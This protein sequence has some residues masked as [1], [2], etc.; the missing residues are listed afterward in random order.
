VT[1]LGKRS[2]VNWIRCHV[3]LID[4]A[5]DLASMVLPT[6]GTSSRSTWPSARRATIARRTVPPLPWIARSTFSAMRSKASWNF[7][8]STSGGDVVIGPPIRGSLIAVR[9]RSR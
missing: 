8:K 7:E 9:A 2:G 1:S 5:R 6:P 3:Q 4:R